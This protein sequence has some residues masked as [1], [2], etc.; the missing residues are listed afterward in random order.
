MPESKKYLLKSTADV[1]AKVDALLNKIADEKTQL[2]ERITKAEGA[3]QEATD[4]MDES[5]RNGDL[6]AYKVAVTEHNDANLEAR[7]CEARMDYIVNH[8][9]MSDEE[10]E[11]CFEAVHVEADARADE[12]KTKVLQMVGQM[13]EYA[14]Q[15]KAI[16]D[17]ANIVLYRLQGEV[18][19][20]WG[21]A[22]LG[23]QNGPK[24][25]V[26]YR[27]MTNFLDGAASSRWYEEA[28][29]EAGHAH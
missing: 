3:E 4:K 21:H 26:D 25:P 28:V 1:D 9:L 22:I 11:S 13:K 20:S 10:Y 23:P 24:N 17:E 7:A 18:K 27:D 15:L 8:S 2:Q 19:H 14:D 6:E 29:K 16:Q 12:I 5:L